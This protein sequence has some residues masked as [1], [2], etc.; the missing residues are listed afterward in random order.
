M[1]KLILKGQPVTN[2]TYVPKFK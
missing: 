1:I 2:I